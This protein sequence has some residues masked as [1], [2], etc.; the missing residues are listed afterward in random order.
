MNVC[1]VYTGIPLLVG[2]QGGLSVPLI[3]LL[4]DWVGG[5]SVKLNW[6]CKLFSFIGIKKSDLVHVVKI[7]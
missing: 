3:I 5:L 6:C 7:M 1:R 4:V 2:W